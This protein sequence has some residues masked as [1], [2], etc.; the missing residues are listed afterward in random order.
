M[1]FIAYFHPNLKTINES[2]HTSETQILETTRIPSWETKIKS[3]NL[4]NVCNVQFRKKFIACM[5]LSDF[6]TLF[7]IY[8][9]QNLFLL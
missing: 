9:L 6:C 1:R 7:I 8:D 5:L 3:K 2:T 4:S